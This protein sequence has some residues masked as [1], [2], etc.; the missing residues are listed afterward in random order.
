MG[1]KSTTLAGAAPKTGSQ[2]SSQTPSAPCRSPARFRQAVGLL[3]TGF[4][5]EGDRLA[6]RQSGNFALSFRRSPRAPGPPRLLEDRAPSGRMALDR[7]AEE[8]IGTNQILAVH[9]A[10]ED[11][12]EV[13]GE[14]GQAPLD[15]RTRL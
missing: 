1:T 8:R 10:S 11:L 13:F 12:A 14:V 2:S 4:G 9:L 15:H 6:P 5:V 7:M 3:L